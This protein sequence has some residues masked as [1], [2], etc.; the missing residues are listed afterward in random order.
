MVTLLFL[1]DMDDV[2]YDYDWRTRMS[3]LTALTGHDLAELRRRWW[4]DD[5]EWAAEA[6]RYPEAIGFLKQAI[7]HFRTSGDSERMKEFETRLRLYETGQPFREGSGKK[8][9][10]LP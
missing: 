10:S 8:D 5:G 2:L 4:N 3:G 7:E 6:G 9:G 1:F